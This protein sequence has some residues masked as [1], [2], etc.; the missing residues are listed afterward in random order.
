MASALKPNRRFEHLYAITRYAT[1]GD[2]QMPLD[3]RFTVTKVVTDSNY[4][5]EEVNRLNQLNKDKG[6]YY[7]SQIT[8]LEEV[9]V[10]SEPVPTQQRVNA[11]SANGARG[12]PTPLPG[13]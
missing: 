10:R 2:D 4:A 7:F 11:D 5:Q 6:Y 8:R 12:V 9:P 13:P 1:Q 3:L